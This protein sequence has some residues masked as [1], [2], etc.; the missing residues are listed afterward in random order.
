MGK[1]G[2]LKT[3]IPYKSTLLI[4]ALLLIIAF[5]IFN[6]KKRKLIENLEGSKGTTGTTGQPLTPAIKTNNKYLEVFLWYDPLNIADRQGERIYLYDQLKNNFCTASNPYVLFQ[7]YDVK[8]YIEEYFITDPVHKDF[9]TNQLKTKSLKEWEDYKKGFSDL[10][11][12]IITFCVVDRNTNPHQRTCLGGAWLT[13]DATLEMLEFMLIGNIY[14]HQIG[15]AI[16]PPSLST[17]T[18]KTR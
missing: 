14:S 12:P 2:L 18:G 16:N 13:F 11:A 9:K 5:S 15:V 3:L 1:S 6:T 7:T 17:V 10:N 4:L 8:D